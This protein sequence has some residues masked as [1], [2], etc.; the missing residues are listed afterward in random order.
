MYSDMGFKIISH[1]W[2]R[3]LINFSVQLPITSKQT[4]TWALSILGLDALGFLKMIIHSKPLLSR[5]FGPRKLER[6][7][8]RRNPESVIKIDHDVPVSGSRQRGRSRLC[9]M[10]G[11][12][13]EMR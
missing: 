6:L 10:D 12:R 9:W 13:S 7:V 2:L 1:H 4:L 5:A 3:H 11:I 8:Q